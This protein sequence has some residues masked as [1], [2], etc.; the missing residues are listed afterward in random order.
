[1]LKHEEI[2]WNDLIQERVVYHGKD[3]SDPVISRTNGSFMYAF[4]SVVD[5]YLSGITHIIRGADHI[6]NTAIQIQMWNALESIYKQGR[7]V[8]FAHLPLFQSK[9]GKISKRVGGFSIREL[10]DSGTESLAIKNILSRLGHSAFDDIIRNDQELI[11]DFDLGKFGKSQVLFDP[12]Q[13]DIINKKVLS[14]YKYHEVS[15]RVP[16]FVSQAFFDVY[17]SEVTS[18]S[19]IAQIYS[20]LM[21]ENTTFKAQ[22]A[23]DVQYVKDAAVFLKEGMGWKAWT[24]M[25][26]DKF[27][28]RSGKSLFLPLRIAITGQEHGP[29]MTSVLPLLP[30]SLVLYRLNN[31]SL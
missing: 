1:M 10:R 11:N 26:K 16:S 8:E 18:I 19:E 31:Y 25:L 6:T 5:D 24:S 23:E 14:S 20:V 9:H 22:K 27:P 4:C 17:K 7:V 29:D 28:S 13:I 30:Y 12:I 21:G 2:A 15:S 3:L